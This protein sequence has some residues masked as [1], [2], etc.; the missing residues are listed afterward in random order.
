MLF[1]FGVTILFGHAK[2]HH[3]NNVG[4][5]CIW[6]TNE[7]VV[8]FDVAIDQVLL[9]DGLHPR[10]L[11]HGQLPIRGTGNRDCYHL[12]RN[13]N[14]RFDREAP[15]TMVKEIFQTGSKQVNDE[16]VVQTFLA[17]V[18]DIGNAS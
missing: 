14:N 8:G 7:E 1:G 12:L 10:Q 5:L 6:S 3:V 2:V 18:V 15:V 16:N 4:S 13:H 9:V 17:K 11:E